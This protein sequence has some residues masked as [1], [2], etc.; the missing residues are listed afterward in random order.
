MRL[1]RESDTSAALSEFSEDGRQ[2]VEHDDPVQFTAVGVSEAFDKALYQRLLQENK[3]IREWG[4]SCESGMRL[5]KDE[6]PN[7]HC[8]EKRSALLAP[9]C[10][11]LLLGRVSCVAPPLCPPNRFGST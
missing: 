6:S 10:M 7:N 5:P 4:F 11:G 9:F 1:I 8:F 2:R 3:V